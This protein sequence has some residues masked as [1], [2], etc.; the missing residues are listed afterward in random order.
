MKLFTDYM[1]AI[2][3]FC[4]EE[5]RR[6]ESGELSVAWMVNAYNYA[7]QRWAVDK[8]ITGEDILTLAAMIEPEK[9]ANGYR[10]VPVTVGGKVIGWQNI[11]RQIAN[12]LEA[13]D[14]LGGEDPDEAQAACEP[15]DAFRR[16]C[17]ANALS[18]YR[19]LEQIHPLLDGNGRLGA[20]LY[21]VKN[22]TLF[23]PVVPPAVQ[24][25]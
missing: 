6:Q 9:N 16:R 13:Q 14:R 12:L 25:S 19:E 11:A 2:I 22:G 1:M 7:C 17:A 4:A 3:R 8:T 23:R 5:C 10:R 15:E 18:F 20:I 24:F 21:N